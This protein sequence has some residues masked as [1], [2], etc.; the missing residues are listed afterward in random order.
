M[1]SQS[2]HRVYIPSN[3]RSNQYI[4]AEF[5]LDDLFY[6]QFLSPAQAYQ[7]ISEHLF[8]LCEERELHNVHLIANDKL[9][10]VRFHEESYC[11]QTKKQVMF[12]YN[13][14]YHE[15]HMCI[16]DADY[17]AKKIRIVFLATGDELRANAAQFHRRVAAVIKEFKT[18]LPESIQSIKVR[19][20]QHLT[21]DLF[22]NAKGNKESYGYKLRSLTPRY[23]T[24]EC[25]LPAEHSEM[26]Y[27]TVSIPLTR[28]IKTQF[29]PQGEQGY[30]NLYRYLEDTFLTACG[31]RKLQ[32][33]AMVANDRIPLVRNSQ[34]DNN[35]Q[36]SELQKISFDPA[37]HDTQYYGFWQEDKL[38]QTV[39]FIL[40][41]G[42]EDKNDIGFGKFM[43][44]VE[45]AMRS[46]ADKFQIP[47]DQ[48]NVT[49]R[50]YQHVSYR[51]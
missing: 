36:N 14:K 28:A 6:Q 40:A 13:P 35:A 48:Q 31:T 42:D 25:P 4:L 26:T 17:V 11:L 37:N 8:T 30:A 46:V 2:Q 41:A 51:V 3:A 19:D 7:K 1:A 34:V 33:I 50:F 27:A 16:E 24:R 20:H 47:A 21:Y 18:T 45:A 39:Y 22:A 15:S 44:S 43:N 9:P 32:R 38:V 29:L 49:I 5:K 12:F 23:Q 10:I